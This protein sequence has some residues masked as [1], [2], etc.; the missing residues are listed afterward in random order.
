MDKFYSAPMTVVARGRGGGG[1]RFVPAGEKERLKTLARGLICA[2][3][4]IKFAGTRK[5]AG[6]R[7]P[8]EMIATKTAIRWRNLWQ[9]RRRCRRRRRRLRSYA[10]GGSGWRTA[11]AVAAP[12]TL[13]ATTM[14]TGGRW[15]GMHG[16]RRCLA[17]EGGG[18]IGRAVGEGRQ[19]RRQSVTRC[20]C[21]CTAL[22]KNCAGR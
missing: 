15:R 17:G 20:V 13:V 2:V 1:V 16:F 6:L 9:L 22:G 18:V 8:W 7:A 5:S 11:A 14:T 3:R 4:A 19:R 10:R 12:S 21:V